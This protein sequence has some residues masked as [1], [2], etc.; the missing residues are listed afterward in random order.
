MVETTIQLGS[1]QRF[2]TAESSEL[3]KP[4][5]GGFT[6]DT[7]GLSHFEALAP[8]TCEDCPD[9]Y[10]QFKTLGP[11]FLGTVYTSNSIRWGD[12]YTPASWIHETPIYSWPQR[13]RDCDTRYKKHKRTT[14]AIVKC[15]RHPRRME[16]L[17][18]IWV[19][20]RDQTYRHLKFIC[21]TTCNP[22]LKLP[23]GR[24]SPLEELC[25]EGRVRGSAEGGPPDLVEFATLH[26]QAM[27]EKF[28]RYRKKKFWKDHTVYGRWFA[29]VTW[30][31]HYADGSR[32]ETTQWMPGEKDL[33]GAIS[34]EI[35]PH[36]HVIAV[37]KYMDKENLTS[38]WEEGT[39][40]ESTDSWWST[41]K[42]LTKYLNKTQLVGRNQGTFGKTYLDS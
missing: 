34:V 25:S 37:A 15:F 32:G 35:H 14:N 27:K 6:G 41:K 22:I 29:E 23:G 31:V 42:Y 33:D 11:E 36:L 8:W 13:C 5:V 1:N 17:E 24:T 26:L 3:G 10:S 2:D 19:Y 12:I 7:S 38:W 20:T 16:K 40:I 18:N 9:P 28:R 30:T 4:P 21:L 39:H